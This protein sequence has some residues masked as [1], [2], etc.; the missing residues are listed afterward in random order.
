MT[1]DLFCSWADHCAQ[2][3]GTIEANSYDELFEEMKKFFDNACGFTGVEAFEISNPYLEEDEEDDG[4]DEG[5]FYE[6][7]WNYLKRYQNLSDVWDKVK[8][9][10]KN[11]W[12]KDYFNKGEKL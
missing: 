10:I 4:E 9:E 11:E 6:W 12:G 5:E 1:F 8:R 2:H 3:S 7:D